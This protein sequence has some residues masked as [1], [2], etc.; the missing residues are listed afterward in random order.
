[1][2]LWLILQLC[3]VA[4]QV[5]VAYQVQG[6]VH[7]GTKVAGRSL[8]YPSLLTFNQ[9]DC[10]SAAPGSSVNLCDKSKLGVG[11]EDLVTAKS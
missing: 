7:T 3:A 9:K 11:G 10:M 6:C 1:M 4:F 8:V 2:P 5:V